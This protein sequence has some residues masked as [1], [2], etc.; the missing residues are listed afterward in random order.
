MINSKCNNIP[1][2]ITVVY[3]VFHR[4]ITVKYT[5]LAYNVIWTV[6]FA[7]VPKGSCPSGNGKR[8]TFCGK[9]KSDRQDVSVLSTLIEWSA[10]PKKHCGITTQIC[11]EIHYINVK[12]PAREPPPLVAG[13]SMKKKD[14]GP[15]P[16]PC[17]CFPTYISPKHGVSFF[18][19]CN[20]VFC[21][22]VYVYVLIEDRLRCSLLR[23]QWQIGGLHRTE[24]WSF[25]PV[26]RSIKLQSHNTIFMILG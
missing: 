4:N 3:I 12:T 6:L 24:C 22:N 13:V 25:F 10:C 9:G 8:W 14:P 21:Y 16:E 15:W 2:N 5:V 23:W 7:N 18:H 17:F 26:K 19:Q 20:V 11:R 1:S